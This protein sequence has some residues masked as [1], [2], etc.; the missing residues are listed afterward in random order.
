L[1]ATGMKELATKSMDMSLGRVAAYAFKDS[2]ASLL[3]MGGQIALTQALGTAAN[4][5]ATGV[6]AERVTD[7]QQQASDL[8]AESD[9]AEAAAKA[10]QAQVAK[11]R[12][13]IEQLE[14]ELENMVEQG[15]QTL[16]I[17][18]GAIDESAESMTHVQQSVS[19]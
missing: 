13:L 10:I 15:Q 1:A 6:G 19:A 3:K 12:A 11:L 2:M 14:Q 8:K 7:L 5:T 16:S 18:F 4:K 17:I 9:Q